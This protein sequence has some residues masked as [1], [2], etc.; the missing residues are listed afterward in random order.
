MQRT[1]ESLLSQA[2]LLQAAG[3]PDAARPLLQ[4]A[5]QT[6]KGETASEAAYELGRLAGERGQQAMA[7][8]WFTNAIG[9]APDSRWAMLALLGTGDSLA[10]LNRKSEA[11]TA[12]TKLVAAVPIDAWRHSTEHAAQRELA[13]EA[14]Y[15]GGTLLRTAGRHGEALNMFVISAM[16]TK[17][18]PAERRALIGAMQCYVAAGDRNTAE[19]LYRQL[20]AGGAEEPVLAEARRALKIVPAESALPRS[21]R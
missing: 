4:T 15:R 13:G 18:S 6:S 19:G 8:E 14:A 7:L 5:V 1:P 17:G 21:T 11:L 2:R 12:Y 3:L 10:A 9:A 20:Q 16:F